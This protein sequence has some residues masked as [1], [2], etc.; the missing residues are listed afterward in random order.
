MTLLLPGRTFPVMAY[1]A[2]NLGSPI[3]VKVKA[4][5]MP[6]GEL[7]S[8]G[9]LSKLVQSKSEAIAYSSQSIR[10]MLIFPKGP[11]RNEG[12]TLID[13][14]GLLVHLILA[15]VLINL[16]PRCAAQCVY[17]TSAERCRI[18]PSLYCDLILSIASPIPK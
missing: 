14:N 13:Y 8:E 11:L 10:T 18:W 17:N 15:L 4:A 1:I 16:N 9:H 2:Q 12:W 7:H 5:S 3:T 6:A